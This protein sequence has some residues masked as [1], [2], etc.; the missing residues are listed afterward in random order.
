M[1]R[2]YLDRSE[3]LLQELGVTPPPVPVHDPANDE[4]FEFEDDVR[5]FI[6]KLRNEREEKEREAAER[7]DGEE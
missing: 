4:V 2:Y 3:E 7:G 5:A 6:E 1:Y